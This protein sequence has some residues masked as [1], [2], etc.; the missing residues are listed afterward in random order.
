MTRDALAEPTVRFCCARLRVPKD[1][2]TTTLD[3]A[4]ERENWCA[5]SGLYNYT[6]AYHD[7]SDH[8]QAPTREKEEAM[9]TQTT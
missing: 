6:C 5:C 2:L 8:P 3:I 4:K 9:F 1:M 7:P